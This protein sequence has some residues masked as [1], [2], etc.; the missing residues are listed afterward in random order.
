MYDNGYI[1]T[2]FGASIVIGNSKAKNVV[3]RNNIGASTDA[4]IINSA[5]I[6]AQIDHNLFIRTQGKYNNETNGTDF[7]IADPLFENAANG[8]F[9]LQVG[10][11][12][13]GAGTTTTLPSVDFTSQL[14]Q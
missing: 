13:I 14:N 8:D 9:R 2:S 7:I 12:A 4:Q 3:I 1:H 6:A 5:K 11:P 10:S